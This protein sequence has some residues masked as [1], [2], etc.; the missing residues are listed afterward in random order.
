MLL[1]GLPLLGQGSA[2]GCAVRLLLLLVLPLSKT[3][4]GGGRGAHARLS[5]RGG[6]RLVGPDPGLPPSCTIVNHLVRV[7]E[8]W[9]EADDNFPLFPSADGG[10]V[11]KN[12]VIRNIR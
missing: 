9:P 11:S 5:V 10:R 2:G 3:D 12:T 6:V 8:K 4:Q 7:R 1:R